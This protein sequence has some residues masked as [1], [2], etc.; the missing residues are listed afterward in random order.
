MHFAGHVHPRFSAFICGKSAAFIQSLSRK[1][2]RLTLL[3]L[4]AKLRAF[5]TLPLVLQILWR[6]SHARL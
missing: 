1:L 4:R 5:V 3:S 6:D 2:A